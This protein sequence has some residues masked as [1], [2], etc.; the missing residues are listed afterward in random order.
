M[1]PCWCDAVYSSW[2]G[3]FATLPVCEQCILPCDGPFLRVVKFAF[4]DFLYQPKYLGAQ[5]RV[6][7]EKETFVS[8]WFD[9][10]ILLLVWE[11]YM[12]HG[13]GVVHNPGVGAVHAS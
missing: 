2:C 3:S 1:L 8:S 6:T 13:V 10:G 9:S 11:R 5:E 4:F 7:R 12:P